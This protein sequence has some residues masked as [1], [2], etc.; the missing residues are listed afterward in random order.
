MRRKNLIN[1]LLCGLVIIT[2]IGCDFS[3]PKAIQVKGEPKIQATS[4]TTSFVLKDK[5]NAELIQEKLGE[6]TK[7]L[8]YRKD[9][10]DTRLQYL[11]EYPLVSVPLDFSEYMGNLN[12]SENFNAAF[13]SQTFEIPTLN[14]STEPISNNT[15]FS[16]SGIALSDL[17][18]EIVINDIQVSLGEEKVFE[19]AKI[20]TVDGGN[21]KIKLS[22]ADGSPIIGNGISAS[23]DYSIKQ[24]SVPIK[25]DKIDF[26]PQSEAF[27][28]LSGLIISSSEIIISGSVTINIASG[29]EIP[30]SF[31]LVCFYDISEFEEIILE[32][33]EGFNLTTSIAENIPADMKQ[34]I[35]EIVFTTGTGG[36][37]IG[38]NLTINNGLPTGNDI[39]ATLTST[40][41]GLTETDT[42]VAGSEDT[43]K[44]VK[45]DAS[46]FV[47][48]NH[49]E[50]NMDIELSFGTGRYD[51]DENQLTILNVEAG[52]TLSLSGSVEFIMDWE[53]MEIAPPS[54]NEMKGTLPETEGLDVSILKTLL[55]DD[56][57]LADIEAALYVSSPIL[58][59]KSGTSASVSLVGKYTNEEDNPEEVCLVGIES[60]GI[61][62]PK[63]VIFDNFDKGESVLDGEIE[64]YS[65]ALGGNSIENLSSL[66]NAGPMDLSFE[67]NFT[68]DEI[69]IEPDDLEGKSA[70]I[71]VSVV[72]IL[73]LGLKVTGTDANPAGGTDIGA[74]FD[75]GDFA[76]LSTTEDLLNRT[77]AT[78]IESG[79]ETALDSIKSCSMKLKYT[80]TVG[81]TFAVVIKDDHNPN[82]TFQ[83]VVEIKK[84]SAEVDLNLT[85]SEMRY[86]LETYP[87]APTVKLFIPKSDDPYFI[88]NNSVFEFNI[89][90]EIVS[91][92]D[93]TFEF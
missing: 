54:G 11:V 6:N 24:D 39:T 32:M 92:I 13:P 55:G 58:E 79:L 34:W 7:V 19:S 36:K 49:T 68:I 9:E 12:F 18:K 66:L 93:K 85:N 17:S 3:I 42:F 70:E 84:G 22:K 91:S 27:I 1:V 47:P 14:G 77:E 57:S 82:A 61:I 5:F 40:T 80:N 73:P 51:A 30:T 75:L 2:I 21:F 81:L 60:G 86:L 50:I 65:P 44:L 67:Y 59:E 31:N 89:I 28:D 8:N 35:K 26:D 83:K 25:T 63:D 74:I 62:S 87:F 10:E 48:N 33:P 15:G 43:K 37:G 16:P 23:Y 76:G 90:A 88:Q 56:I 69:T 38:V 78:A 45:S 4:G 71:N 53:S 52:T 46:P 41:F 72:M 64:Y 20:A 29:T